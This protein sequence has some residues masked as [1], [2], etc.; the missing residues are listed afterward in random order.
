MK[1]YYLYVDESGIA[2]LLDLSYEHFLLTGVLVSEEEAENMNGYFNIMKRKYG[3]NLEF[4]FHSFDLFEDKDSNIYLP[5][6]SAKVFLQSIVEFIKVFPLQVKVFHAQKK[7]FR[8][9]GGLKDAEDYRGSKENKTKKEIIYTLAATELFYWFTKFLGET[10]FVER[11]NASGRIV[12]DSRKGMDKYLLQAYN[13]CKEKQQR[14]NAEERTMAELAKKRLHSITFSDKSTLTGGLE[15]VDL[16]SY[17][18]FH[19]LDR[20]RRLPRYREIGFSN[21]VKVV[22]EECNADCLEDLDPVNYRSLFHKK[23]D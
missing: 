9:L 20:K 14:R 7:N 18:F 22:R 12:V 16:I 6:A 4:P 23:A 11:N 21:V 17:A 13:N 5:D 15:I 1:S 3:L 19:S 8:K 2:N 10:D